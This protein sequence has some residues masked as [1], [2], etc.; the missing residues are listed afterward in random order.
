[1]FTLLP[2]FYK[3][4]HVLVSFSLL[5]S[6][7]APAFLTPT[8]AN[9]YTAPLPTADSPESSTTSP[10]EAAINGPLVA[11]AATWTTEIGGDETAARHDLVA[12]VAADVA[13]SAGSVLTA[14][15]A[16][17]R[18][19]GTAPRERSPSIPLQGDHPSLLA[20][21]PVT[22]PPLTAVV[23]RKIPATLPAES[24]A[25]SS[26]LFT[27]QQLMVQPEQLVA[28]Q[29]PGNSLT[30]TISLY[31]S[32]DSIINWDLAAIITDTGSIVTTTNTAVGPLW[33][34]PAAGEA[35]RIASYSNDV[36]SGLYQAAAFSLPAYTEIDTIQVEGFSLGD[37]LDLATAFS[38]YIY[39]DAAGQ[40]AGQP[41]DGLNLAVWQH[42]AVAPLTNSAGLT[43]TNDG[44][45]LHLADAGL[46]PLGLENGRYWL[47]AFA[48]IDNYGP[49]NLWAW[50]DAAT[51][52]GLQIAPDNLNNLPAGWQTTPT[53]RAFAL[54][55]RVNC[56]SQTDGDWLLT[57]V[58]SGQL[59][60]QSQTDLTVTFGTM[61]L[62][63]GTYQGH[64]C[65][66]SDHDST[67]FR[68]VAL[69]H[70]ALNGPIIELLPA[71]ITDT[72]AVG[73]TVTHSLTIQ[74][75]GNEDL[76]YHFNPLHG[77]GHRFLR[78]A[79]LGADY[80]TPNVVDLTNQLAATNRF[81]QIDFINIAE[82]TPS[83]SD[84]LPYDALLVYSW[85]TP[86][87]RTALG[88]VVADYIDAGGGVLVMYYA[89]MQWGRLE[90]RFLTDG[91]YAL[92]TSNDGWLWDEDPVDIGLIND[93]DHPVLRG[94]TQFR[95]S[96][97]VSTA[98][99]LPG[100]QLIASYS[101]GLPMLAERPAPNTQAPRLDLNS[102]PISN[103]VDYWFWD[104]ATD[105]ALLMTNALD[106]VALADYISSSSS[107]GTIAAG[108]SAELSLTIDSSSL[109][110]DTYTSLL[111]F[112][113]NDPVQ[114]QAVLP[115]T[116]AVTG[117]PNLTL[118]TQPLDLGETFVGQSSSHTL[119]I[120]NSG[121]ADLTIISIDSSHPDVSV[122]YEPEPIFP[123]Q[124]RPVNVI[125]TPQISGTV[126]ATLDVVTTGGSG[127]IMVNGRGLWPPIIQINP[128]GF[129]ET[130]AAGSL[131]TR[132]LVI[133]NTGASDLFF[134]ILGYN[135]S[136]SEPDAFGYVW[137]DNQQPLSPQYNWIDARSL[138]E[139]IGLYGGDVHDGP[140]DIGFEF[141][142]YEN[143]YSQFFVTTKGYISF[144]SGSNVWN[145]TPIPST[146]QPNNM[147]AAFWKDLGMYNW[148]NGEG[149]YL[150]RGG[151]APFRYT[152]IEW[153]R[154]DA[155]AGSGSEDYTFQIILYEQGQ[156][157]V[158]YGPLN[159][160]LTNVTVGIE[161]ESG[162]VGLQYLRNQVGLQPGLLVEY[163]TRQAW[164]DTDPSSGT[165]APGNSLPVSV[166][167]DATDLIGGVYRSD[168][169]LA[170]NDPVTPLLTLPIT[171][172][173]VGTPVLALSPTEL[174][175]GPVFVG[176]TATADILLSS[177]GTEAVAVTAVAS[178]HPDLTVPFTPTLTLPV[179]QSAPLT[180]NYQPSSDTP[181]T[182]TVTITSSGGVFTVPVTGAGLLPPV[183]AVQPDQI[184]ETIAAGDLITRS[185]TLTNAGSSD[186]TFSWQTD[187]ATIG[188]PD[189]A[190]PRVLLLT[191]GGNPTGA[192]TSLASTGLFATADIDILDNPAS[193]TLAMLQPYDVVLAWT[194]SSFA[195]P[196]A[197][198]DVL[199]AYVDAGGGVVLATYAYTTNWG[200]QGG[201]L[202]AGYSPFLPGSTQSVSGQLDMASLADPAHP[203]FSGIT[204]AP[205]YWT[206][207]S[208]SNPT[209]NSGGTL[210]AQD[211]A[212]NRV[213]AQNETGKVVGIVIYPGNLGSSSIQA[214]LM[215]ANA[216]Y[217]AYQPYTWLQVEPS[218]GTILPG[219]S[220]NVTLTLDATEL[221]SGTYQTDL[222]LNSNDP[223]T[224]AITVPVTLTVLGTPLLELLPGSVDFGPVYVGV[225]ATTTV[226]LN[227]IGTAEVAVTAV[228]SSHP[229][230]T[231]V[232]T[233]TQLIPVGQS[234]LL[235]LHYHPSSDTPLTATVTITSSGGVLTLPVSGSGLLPPQINVAPAAVI[236]SL[237]SGQN[238]TQQVVIS[239]TGASDLTFNIDKRTGSNVAVLGAE[240]TISYAND[241]VD[242]LVATGQF[243]SV[244]FINV[245]A[246]VPTLDTLQAYDAVLV[247]RNTSFWSTF[248]MG[249]VLADYV[250]SGGGVV[251]MHFA[252]INSGYLTGRFFND[253]YYAINPINSTSQ[254]GSNLTLGAVHLPQ[255]P[256]LQ[257][258]ATFNGGS[259]SFHSSGSL[260]DGAIVIAE[261][262]NGRPLIV[263]KTVA[264]P[265]G[266]VR[267][268]DL[269]FFPVS[270]DAL[271]SS[272]QAGT[273]GATLMANAL[274]YVA[275]PD[276]VQVTPAEGVLA[277]DSSQPIT[278]T[279]DAT[280]LISGT[281]ATILD[282][283]HNDPFVAPL[284]LPVTMTV[285]GTAVLTT[286]PDSLDF[287][288][289]FVGVAVTETLLLGNVGT[290][291]LM[292]TAVSSDHPDVST[293]FSQPISVAI[294][295]QQPL[296]ITY[297]PTSPAPL[298][299]TVTITSSGGVLNIPITGN[300][301]LP[302]V[303]EVSPTSIFDS[304]NSDQIVTHQLVISNTGSS[305]LFFDIDQRAGSGYL[306]VAVL[307]AENTASFADDV[308]NKLTATGQFNSVSFI[309]V[310]AGSPTLETL[311]AYD[312]VL[313]FRRAN[314]WNRTQMGNVLADYVDSGGGVVV[315]HFA[316]YNVG[317]MLGRFLNDGYHVIDP[318][319]SLYEAQTGSYF[320]LGTIHAPDHPV[321][322]N[323]ATFNGGYYSYRS[324]GVLTAGAT[325]IAE[326]S[327]G[328]PLVVEKTVATPAG[329]VRRVDLN[330]VPISSD[331][332][333]G[334]WTATSDGATLMANAL[335]YVVEP[336][337]V[338]VSPT[339]GSVAVGDN[340]TID[341]TLD[342]TDMVS[343]TYPALLDIY[344]NDPF[345]DP[346]RLPVTLFVAGTAVLT[347]TPT[348]LDFGTVFVGVTVSDTLSLGNTG[349]ADL[350]VTAVGSD[351]P[352]VS[353]SFSDPLPIAVG[354]SQ[355][356][357][358]SYSPSSQGSL[359]ATV[360]LTST[361]GV[362]TV[363]VSGHGLLPPVIEIA[364]DHVDQTLAAGTSI[365][366]TLF[367]SNTGGSDLLFDLFIRGHL[368]GS[369]AL[370]GL[371]AETRERRLSLI[372]PT[373]LFLPLPDGATTD[374]I[375]TTVA[376]PLPTE[377][378]TDHSLL[379]NSLLTNS[380]LTE[381]PDVLLL[382]DS[383]PWGHTAI[384]QILQAQE[385]AYDQFGSASIATLDLMDYRL[386][387]IPSVQ[388]NTFCTRYNNHLDKFEAF[389]QAGGI[390]Q[391]HG[392]T[393]SS[394]TCR[395]QLPGGG[396]NSQNLQ[397]YNYLVEPDHPIVSGI[398][399]PF[400][401]NHA[402]HNSFTDYPANTAVIA[403]AGTG[404][405]GPATLL[406]YDHGF[407][408]VVATGQTVEF[409]WSN[410]WAG[411]PI[412][413]NMIAYTYEMAL[414]R[415]AW[416]N[417]EPTSGTV[418][419]NGSAAISVT[420]DATEMISGTYWADVHVDSNDP[421]TPRV[422]VPV[423]M[424][425][426]GVPVLEAA[427]D[428]LAFGTVYVGV[429]AVQPITVSNSGTA[430]LTLLAASSSHPDVAVTLTE[431]VS[432]TPGA[433]QS[434]PVTFAPSAQLPISATLTFT[435]TDNTT[436]TLLVTGQGLLP[437]VVETDPTSFEETIA[438][439]NSLTRTLTI[440]NSGD[441]P[442]TYT[443][444]T[445]H[446]G[447]TAVL[448]LFDD[449]D[450]D[451]DNSQ[452]ASIQGAI[453]ST[454]CGAVSG[455]ALYFRN[456]PRLADTV[457]LDVTNGG[458]IRFYLKISQENNPN[459]ERAD[460]GED[461]HLQY[462]TDGGINWH[463]IN[464]Y[465]YNAY[466]EFALV[467]E[468]VPEEAHS[469]QTRFR[470]RQFS[471]SGANFDHWAIDDLSIYAAG[472]F[473]SVQP[474]S[475]SLLP[476][477][478]T[479]VTV[480]LDATDLISATYQANILI[481]SND[482]ATPQAAVPVTLH[483]TGAPLI[484]PI[485]TALDMGT[486]FVG[487]ANGRALVIENSG[488]DVL[489]IS[490]I[491]SDDT[492]LSAAGLP[493]TIPPR[494]QRQIPVTYLPTAVGTLD[495]NL[496][497]Y[498]SDP[499]TPAQVIPVTGEAIQPPVLTFAP[500]NF[501]F[502]VNTDQVV[503]QTLTLGNT[504][505]SNLV[506]D[507][508]TA[509][510]HVQLTPITGTIPAGGQQ[511]ISVTVNG[512]Q[513]SQ[514]S[515]SDQIVINSNDPQT[516][517][518][519]LPVNI[520]VVLVAP[521]QPTNPSPQD[522]E[523]NVR[524]DKTLTWQAPPHATSYDLTLWL[525]GET[526]P[527]T[528]TVTGL[529][530]ASY[531]PPGNFPTN[532]R[533]N[534]DV[535]AR[536][537]A[538]TTQGPQWTFVT[539]TLP[540]LEVTSIT[541][542][543][544]AFSGQPFAVSWI[545]TNNGDRG[546]TIATWYDRVYL[547]ASPVF[548]ASTA[549]YLGQRTNPAYL[550][551]GESYARQAT[552][553]MPQGFNGNYYIFVLTDFYNWM[554][555]SDETNNRRVSDGPIDVQLTPPPDLQVSQVVIP[556]DAFSASTIAV[557]WSV[558]NAGT[559]GTVSSSWSDRIY[560]SPE[561]V[562]DASNAMI[563]GTFSRTGVLAPGEGYTRTQD[564]T[565]PHA[566]FGEHY[567][568]VVTDIFNQVFEYIYDDNNTS[569]PAG[570]LN[571]ILSPPPDLEVTMVTVPPTAVSGSSLNMS[572]RVTNMGGGP[573]F[574][575]FWRDRIYLSDSPTFTTTNATVLAT[576]NRWGALDVGQSYTT[577][578]DLT[579][580]NGISGTHY[581]HVWTD[582]D[583]HVFEF[584]FDDN[585]VTTSNPIAVVL[586]ESPDLIV[587]EVS[588][589]A[590][591]VVGGN[592][593]VVNWTVANQGEATP[594][595]AWQDRIYLSPLPTW[596]GTGTSLGTFTRP[597][598][599]APGESYTQTRTVVVPSNLPTNNY[600]LYVWTDVN[601][602]IY[603]HEAE[604]NNVTRAPHP[605]AVTAPG[606]AA[607]TDLVIGSVS[608][609]TAG[610]SGGTIAV[611]WTV[612]NTA[613]H[614]T[615]ATS[616]RDGVYLSPNTTL[617]PSTDYLLATRVRSGALAAGSSY[618]RNIDVTLPNGIEGEY[619]LFFRNDIDNQVNDNIRGN[620]TTYLATPISITLSLSPDL[621]PTVINP[622][623]NA[624]AG[625]PL[626]LVWSVANQ[627]EATANGPWYDAVYLSENATLETGDQRLARRTYN[628]NLVPGAVYTQTAS[629]N[630]PQGISGIYYL[631]LQTDSR[632]DV[633]EHG[634]E[635]NNVV[636]W[637][638]TVTIAPPADLTVLTVTVPTTAVPGEPITINW[639]IQNIGD[640]PAS[641]QM[642]DAV[643]I[644]GDTTWDVNDAH[645]GNHCRT[646]NLAPGQTA[647]FEMLTTMPSRDVLANLTGNLTGDMP[648]VTPGE[649]YAIV[650]TD[651][652]NNINESDLTNNTGVSTD[653]IMV[654]VTPLTLG[655]PVSDMLGTG[656]G[657]F[658]RVDV[659]AGQTLLVT[660]NSDNGAA[661]NELYV[662]YGQVPSRSS[663]DYG[664]RTPLQA[665][666]EVVVPTTR[667]GTYY[668]LAFGASVPNN[669]QTVSL[670][671]DLLTFGLRSIQP[672]TG[673]QGGQVTVQLDGALFRP[674][675]VVALENDDTRIE[676]TRLYWSNPALAYA[677]FDLAD[678]TLDTYD[679]HLEDNNAVAVL[680]DAFTVVTAVSADIQVTFNAPSSLRPGQRGLLNIDYSNPG[681]TD[682]QAPMLFVSTNN[683]EFQRPGEAE[684]IGSSI[685]LLAS[686]RRGP[687][688]TL[689]P[690]ASGRISLVFNPSISD[691]PVTF[692][693]NTM[694]TT[695]EPI[696]WSAVKEDARPPYISP[697]AWNAIW[698]N[699]VASVGNNTDSLMN[700]LSENA[701]YLSLIDE[702]ADD[703]NGLL[704]FEIQQA[705]NQLPKTALASVV[706]MTVPTPGLSLTFA[707]AHMQTL[708][709]RYAQGALGRGWTHQWDL[710]IGSN[711]DDGIVWVQASGGHRYFL[712][713]SDGSYEG[714][715]GETG[716]LQRVGGVYQLREK[717]GTTLR[718]RLDGRLNYVED[719]N[720]NRITASYAGN[721][722]TNLTH[723]N[724]RTLTFTYNAFGR[725]SQ[726]TDQT[727][728]TITYQYDATGQYLIGVT[729]PVGTT[730]YTYQTTG[731]N[732]RRHALL[733]IA[734]PGNTHHYFEYDSRGRLIREYRDGGAE[735]ISYAYGP[736]NTVYL[737]NALGATTK[738]SF[739]P[740]FQLRHMVDPFGHVTQYKYDDNYRLAEIISAVG[741]TYT[742]DYDQMGNMTRL[743]NPL[744]QRIEM[745]YDP[746]FNQM[747]S[748]EDARGYES[749]FNYDNQGNLQS[750]SYPDGSSE[751]FGSDSSGNLSS[752]Q[753][754]R[755]QA[756]SYS[757]NND[758]LVTGKSHTG[759][760]T[761]YTY[762]SRGNLLTATDA[763]GTIEMG[764]DA[765][766]RLTSIS[767]PTGR[768]LSFTY[769]AGGR[770]TQSVDQDGFVVD[771]VYDSVGRLQQ[772][773][774]GSGTVMVSYTYNIAGQ[775]IRE[776]NENG[777][778]TLYAYDLLGRLTNVAHHQTDGTLN[779]QYAYTY[780]SLG[781]TASMTTDEGVWDYG[782][783]LTGQLTSITA[784]DGRVI[785][786][787]YD[788]AGNRIRVDD[789]GDI[790]EYATN[791][792]N[793]YTAV[794]NAVYS[795]DADGNLIT[796][797]AGGDLATYTYDIE[798]RLISAVTP[799]A[800]VSYEYDALGQRVAA[801]IDGQR[802]EYLIDPVGLSSV[803]S[804]FNEQ[805]DLQRRFTYGLGLVNQIQS[806]GTRFYYD[807]DG[808]GSVVGLTGADGDYLNRYSYLPFGE[809]LT[810]VELVA[811]PYQHLGSWG[812]WQEANDLRFMR[813]R[814]YD[815]NTG[816]FTSPDPV[817][818]IGGNT[819][820]Y[821]YVNNSPLNAVDPEGTFFV[822]LA[823]AGGIIGGIVNT[824]VY[825]V[826]QAATGQ[827]ITGRGALAAGVT[828]AVGG[829]IIGGTGGIGFAASAGL[830]AG[831]GALGYGIEH[832]G[833]SSFSWSDMGRATA[834]GGISGGLAQAIGS[835]IPV[836]GSM[837]YNAPYWG[838]GLKGKS[839]IARKGFWNALL[840][841]NK[842]GKN[843]YWQ[844][845]GDIALGNLIK[846]LI[847]NHLWDEL[848]ELLDDL[849]TWIIRPFDPND[850]LGPPGYGDARWVP[851]DSIL[852]YTIRF[853]NDPE[854]ASAPA[855]RVTI[856]QL[857]DDALDLRTFRLH[858]FGFGDH[859]FEVPANR[860]FY[861]TRLDLV[862]EMNLY[863]DFTA[864]V[865]V[866]T[867]EAFWF[868]QSID[869]ET[870]APP[871]D[872]LAGF[873]PPNHEE[874]EGEGFVTYSIRP[875]SNVQTGDVVDA[876][877][878][879]IFDTEDPIDTPPIF[880]TLDAGRPTSAVDP[881]PERIAGDEVVLTWSG[882]DDE[883]GSGLHSVDLYVSVDD[884]P[885]ALVETDI[886]ESTV[887]FNG[888]VG[889][890]YGFF[891]L[892]RDNAGN[893]EAT[894]ITAD[895][896][897]LLFEA[898]EP[899]LIL[900]AADNEAITADGYSTSVITA[901]V[902][903]A[904]ETLLPGE[905]VTFTTSLGSLDVLTAT[906][907]IMGVVTSTLT[908]GMLPGTA[909]VSATAGEASETITLTLL[910]RPVSDLTAA[911]S[912]PTELGQ[913][914]VFTSTI[915]DGSNV[916]YLWAF[917]DG[918][919]ASGAGVSHQYGEAG[920]Y[921]AVVTASNPVSV[922]T[923][924]TVVTITDIPIAGLTASNSSP[925]EL[926]QITA[927]TATINAGS[928]VTYT[929]YLG[930]GA[931]GSGPLVDHTYAEPGVYTAVVTASNSVNIVTATTAITITDI[932]IAGLTA[933]NSSPTE[934][935]QA[936]AL[937]AT[938]SAGSNVTYTWHLGDGTLASG[939]LVDHTYAEAGVY[940][941]VVTASNSV[942]VLTATTQITVTAVAPPD[943]P[944]SGLVISSSAPT[945]LGDVTYFTATV[946]TGTNVVYT[947]AFGDGS[948]GQGAKT[949]H[950][951]TERG[952][953]TVIVTATN[954]VSS[955]TATA[956]VEITGP[957]Q[958]FLPMI[959]RPQAVSQ[960]QTTPAYLGRPILARYDLRR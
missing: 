30:Q 285:A 746:I 547:S 952:S 243:D 879:I 75:H 481:D 346:V 763:S 520:Q 354:G 578:R 197:V 848:R 951:Y 359:T 363:P 564:V 701:N 16:T 258:V 889:Y 652:L 749:L 150:Y 663:F 538:G 893:R 386:I 398:S 9:R 106:Y 351:H 190:T 873:L 513:F 111:R 85:Y 497:I 101:N 548:D 90:G 230:L 407:G 35:G 200:M 820:L 202:D 905:V 573:T 204:T 56:A 632:N 625:Q 505:L 805:G 591:A 220:E 11:P 19:I 635:D 483:V 119:P 680:A 387:I 806:D 214:R 49:N 686:N 671:A 900:L 394:H 854:L 392:A 604:D 884:G 24:L 328:Q 898:G 705:S 415:A 51:P 377:R 447:G 231:P 304:L 368:P 568:F 468:I 67:P 459:C 759:G 935:G 239:N 323:V 769:D 683:A 7:I 178:S 163:A 102:F 786:Y 709:G 441:S 108:G 515:Y 931:L 238:M 545:V 409:A 80:D 224:P 847:D 853:E 542:P 656:N 480:Q 791:N 289:V 110:S 638:I 906:T 911:N 1:M 411:G 280:N 261:Y 925:T 644:S 477:Q 431:T 321:M 629:V 526:R 249:N 882:S 872:A 666:Q 539:E 603:E 148:G 654:D 313:V 26:L 236:A 184:D 84:L 362:L 322:E 124:S 123:Y 32:S 928:N 704:V 244:A 856:D 144:G 360:T 206:S 455:N 490:A 522:N 180:I 843:F 507:L 588:T 789:D 219:S 201:V 196:Q 454:N 743:T 356:L 566:I 31:N 486:A 918:E 427:P 944:I 89:F 310:A 385:V 71:A 29:V 210:L 33:Q 383:N 650:R 815:A 397:N 600:Y 435:G 98:P 794:G 530:S 34:Q 139:N 940:T 482:P 803:V 619:Y 366:H 942:N 561:P 660:L 950:T 13:A 2:V 274:L 888:M 887:V 871:V 552:F 678:A 188:L 189:R 300:S 143:S 869:P 379:T 437:P 725:I 832:G 784:P 609:P 59:M 756:I 516:G 42:T 287:G 357:S 761:T 607:P 337:F 256:L 5:G 899:S 158:Q 852:D 833:T 272:W 612:T 284:T 132:N 211:T 641:G 242:K 637:P 779:A 634:A 22:E 187:S 694:P 551:P 205:T 25:A 904:D 598:N 23:R 115:L 378:A 484:N 667:A 10:A 614:A 60:P 510:N 344:H 421:F 166:S 259:S 711:N 381:G 748:V 282:I 18:E 491:T 540:D 324:S 688:G 433:A 734:Y 921:T 826:T 129:D 73:Q 353:T 529:S 565:L 107:T 504:G 509:A 708:P 264:T 623:A 512:V 616:W 286:Q 855:Q 240:N 627:G 583:G 234:Y 414:S 257:N 395:P 939:P 358:I 145:T 266:D 693:A 278:V 174:D 706:D 301:L 675:M 695:S 130:V 534:W 648:G 796:R 499:D 640:S 673:G 920:V 795:Y 682:I 410:G 311:Q 894:K 692:S 765:A 319:N 457:D 751:L 96:Y 697:D 554:R 413:E 47:L 412:L 384:Q 492:Q 737:T 126:N 54:M 677:T 28:H 167:L 198:G 271:S 113:S 245:A 781:R 716:T 956:E 15:V 777:T 560:L 670:Q 753:N 585:N 191:N 127:Q 642:C 154:A 418:S 567:L 50:Q 679:V 584:I 152:V 787:Q 192:R 511:V 924:T 553:N 327:N 876:E 626:D 580:P 860:S 606:E 20:E 79:I 864:G 262:S 168:L 131:I 508:G 732:A 813:A 814:Y 934:L 661:A 133:S 456:S 164:L 109:I 465:A 348:S 574:E 521:G 142:F 53:S 821:S 428:P 546:T 835:R 306:N 825:V 400:Y 37:G 859:F 596:S 65:L 912:S 922:L 770:R 99:L 292:V 159:G 208:Y 118:P 425:V 544:T 807:L 865:N 296:A 443:L 135:P 233:A 639:T 728:R 452:W 816:R 309:N 64:L 82:T 883:G 169:R 531:N 161:N 74:N 241:V 151:A 798:N 157:R 488:T 804:E 45:T 916:S 913:S 62:A 332:A 95:P 844:L 228:A 742:F 55:G 800:T 141:P 910:D 752:W 68:F 372:R 78:V 877:A 581:L 419:A 333:F 72:L 66:S 767:Y 288:T 77:Q 365:T 317:Y 336:D 472:A 851:A 681:N 325:V 802:T 63:A 81:E 315:M 532:T 436:T 307:G 329:N 399:N 478:Q 342:A 878:Q 517:L 700:R 181:L 549:T 880:N 782:Y 867:G 715:P 277:A 227:S 862:D 720:G 279:L 917:G 340:Q 713:Q 489:H 662:R 868:F 442:L 382:L 213:V 140:I 731:S 303:I 831:L 738:L 745:S 527:A 350:V 595:A 562:F 390:L 958:L 902:M 221:I 569:D 733:S 464:I 183:I 3:A 91:Y 290:A 182:A 836:P 736:V 374:S 812:I 537:N 229:D 469:A 404:P 845:F 193:L 938:I 837:K 403:T 908:A 246:G 750:I 345:A 719:N 555:E 312:A 93:P 563:L 12:A 783:D 590:S 194:G 740:G 103:N 352:D 153:H 710:S 929:W 27:P 406:E 528:P 318:V 696:D 389:V 788:A 724:G 518:V 156:I 121:T 185:L 923:A 535:L 919:T 741:S 771:Y 857:L 203:I 774:D 125:F 747:T 391:L 647:A 473:A 822:P 575:S 721:L 594:T 810:S 367:I 253:G 48:H 717:D 881:L 265:A 422:T 171:M 305:E 664:F 494:E 335:R 134:D 572:W 146:A 630:I 776:D 364:P 331:V 792:L 718:F 524:I 514:G 69:T 780:D 744:G 460:F 175:F 458:L 44:L 338:T 773:R 809:Q 105:G 316:L 355:P 828:G 461:V 388:G 674:D 941:A 772:L 861:Q 839:W 128:D 43:M 58:S 330:F 636:G 611:S 267:R 685:S 727:G 408:L 729:A 136:A 498:S 914:T 283:T 937:T 416:L 250:D 659:P 475:G 268:V 426:V 866:I 608:G 308:V 927:L 891:T 320:G 605:I 543:P 875:K 907:N 589:T 235:P 61:G 613:G 793:Q 577:T 915:S 112:S 17:D 834:I 177:L 658:Y 260:T 450:P 643:F 797:Q 263:E 954:A 299:A 645:V 768:S 252:L 222:L 448:T 463:T 550:G 649:Y 149:I 38:W 467:E 541:V 819:N 930:D 341:V 273:D 691:G 909:V 842:T 424:T 275:Q 502:S 39:A 874:G 487:Y 434:L 232:L 849:S 830:G 326:Y 846:Y 162:T 557:S 276:F 601:D 850:I 376:A 778:Y 76:V 523:L 116:L 186:L 493:L 599:L 369:Q 380:L 417:V 83:L 653:T 838:A 393:Q 500:T 430:D 587:P 582:A 349:T 470:W 104:A 293:N 117:V 8:H 576:V 173:V 829:A 953:Y 895:T 420:L 890:T 689:P 371:D 758:G 429:T 373:E 370:H 936:T 897:T 823:V 496:I 503:T 57:N 137:V 775:L 298:M 432:L 610:D 631:L 699:F 375:T 723:S 597:V 439:G 485:T 297:L 651:I 519:S 739:D 254:T 571:I 757:Y 4:L 948:V 209:L 790:T 586:A 215:F 665:D 669:N 291:D 818:L 423:T 92:N 668:I 155:W 462:S 453:A 445:E 294:N 195:N 160:S 270:N 633:Y 216:L 466:P 451:I 726:L 479:D 21:R 14:T 764:Y 620:N 735:E 926:G 903:D 946:A 827:Q 947:W 339:V 684:Y 840:G 622:P 36:N 617:N 901:T 730:S 6:S 247:F 347:S 218:E 446:F 570:P 556:L 960:N 885:F 302:P 628:G 401:G 592:P 824:G 863:V 170:S 255:H 122:T 88:N 251:V 558:V 841:K 495:A 690:G 165:L 97:E 295:R 176:A 248:Q 40:P 52:G 615:V 808:I 762:D 602:H 959:I 714:V 702:R 46:A 687:A 559:G 698:D 471:F 932:P 657:R 223:V 237:D 707:R 70:H 624:T 217:F 896:V 801:I 943:I 799:D 533:F 618:Q 506:F 955:V 945:Q 892:A 811:N 672:Q 886:T 621:V 314:F 226:A 179:G 100:S 525:D 536:N 712:R 281:Y 402:S 722:L 646:I 396:V 870:G 440:S 361:G 199:R 343:G 94:V 579:L 269:N 474:D 449:F 405:G 703:I 760:S 444:A 207:S 858:T 147:I 676:A 817:G 957:H 655:E 593:I 933:S 87:N 501:S 86:Q 138:G 120:T 41:E 225:T 785:T 476:G 766:S 172:T 212:G 754:R 114:S 949:S 755:G 334:Y 438:A